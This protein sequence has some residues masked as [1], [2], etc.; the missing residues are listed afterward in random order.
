M[1]REDPENPHPEV[2]D[3]R[4]VQVHTDQVSF[5][6]TVA[7]TGE[8]DLADALHLDQAL[9]AGAEQLKLAGS[10]ESLDARRAT[11]LGEMSAPSSPSPTTTRPA[12]PP[13]RARRGPSDA[14]PAGDVVR[15]PLRAGAH[16]RGRWP[17]RCENTRTPIDADKIRAWC[18]HPD[19]T[20]TSSRSS[21]WP[22]H[23]RVDQ[24]EV[25]DRLKTLVDHRDGH[26]VFPWCTRP[27]RAA[28]T[29]TWSRST[30]PTRPGA[31]LRLQHRPH[32][33]GAIIG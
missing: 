15:A 23:V 6:G 12:R 20:V 25:P 26:C 28:T 4:H 5:T 2:A 24:Y 32:S 33:A 7:V 18:G 13:S 22:G 1:E 8:L 30:R 11:A 19:A 17:G 16:R 10:T 9:A 14:R 21:T 29:T 3:T 27:A 31:D